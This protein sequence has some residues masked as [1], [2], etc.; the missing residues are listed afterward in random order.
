MVEVQKLAEQLKDVCAIHATS[1][2]KIE[3][4]L[5]KLAEQLVAKEKEV[6]KLQVQLVC[7]E[8]EVKKQLE[9]IMSLLCKKPEHVLKPS[10]QVPSEEGEEARCPERPHSVAS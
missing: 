4:K 6:R 7:K 10:G 8:E 9:R 2:R 5:T 3:E 1:E